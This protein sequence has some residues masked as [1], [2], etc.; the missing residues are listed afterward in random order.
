MDNSEAATSKRL[1]ELEFADFETR[2]RKFIVDLLEPTLHRVSLFENE[3][4]SVKQSLERNSRALTEINVLSIRAEQQ[5]NMVEQLREEMSKWDSQRRVYES[6]LTEDLNLLKSDMDNVRF[7]L[8][9]RDS[10]IQAVER[11]CERLGN[12]VA[13]A[14]EANQVLRDYTDARLEA[15][16]SQ[17]ATLRTE[18]EVKLISLETKHNT[19]ADELW[20][21]ETG[22]AKVSAEVSRNAEVIQALVEDLKRI[23]KTKIDVKTFEAAQN[24]THELI[25]DTS[26]SL[27]EL[28]HAVASVVQ[29][30]KDH[31]R[32]ASNTIAA[33][34]AAM[35][36]EV[37]SMYSEE[38]E[39]SA[40]M[41]TDVIKFM[42]ETEQHVKD[43][44]SS[45]DMTRNEIQ[46]VLKTVADDMENVEKRAK[47]DRTE[48]DI[49]LKNI[50]K[51]MAG[52]LDNSHVVLK[53]LEHLTAVLS[54]AL[55][56][57]RI[58]TTLDIQDDADRKKVALMGYKNDSNQN[59]PNSTSLP[60]VPPPNQTSRPLSSS[61]I[62]PATAGSAGRVGGRTISTAAN[63]F[64]AS[65][66]GGL[67][68]SVD[69][70]CLSCTSQPATVLAGFKLACIQYQP[71]AV[72][73]NNRSFNRS[74]L[75]AVQQQLLEQAH[76]A[77]QT[78]P[79]QELS[80]D[81]INGTVT[82]QRQLSN[83]R[84][85]S[86]NMNKIERP[87]SAIGITR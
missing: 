21:E 13:N 59:N 83:V 66:A 19:L 75:L 11:T 49:D 4:S 74:E 51:R 52:V 82:P 31:F 87:A 18:M 70:K 76:E 71:G 35:L 54:I 9:R 6:R 63:N 27:V 72:R 16:T 12:D 62:R 44:E 53:G 10:A 64:N 17:N 1:P 68:M 14:V 42:R 37:R 78:G 39:Q 81:I 46:T 65:S 48:I 60:T 26:G 28:R 2:M 55:E 22:L 79:D 3:L 77:L 15:Q 32:T 23:N 25:R 58:S 69:N 5:L 57:S 61:S 67:V 45:V 34:N 41:R 56:A 50:K 85:G 24:E 38:L 8:D 73:F 43:V 86:N 29:E 40:Q 84:I 36:S 30:V 20:G 47:K 7:T 80:E 33:H